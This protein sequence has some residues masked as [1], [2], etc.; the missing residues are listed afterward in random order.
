MKAQ[1]KLKEVSDASIK[2]GRESIATGL[3]A[4]AP[5]LAATKAFADQED[6]MLQM[7]AELLGD[8][9]TLNQK[10]FSDL[11]AYAN[12]AA[13]KYG[14]SAAEYMK[15]IR[16][17]RENSIEPKDILGGI[18]DAV[19]KLSVLF[20]VPPDSIAQFAARMKQDMGILPKEMIGM[21]DLIA[22][23]KNAG[24]GKDGAEAVQEMGE[25]FSK[26][27][28]GAHNLGV[29]GL[30]SAKDLGALMGIFISQGIWNDFR[31]L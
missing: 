22:R 10:V 1:K 3:A 24:V 20:H 12:G 26:A 11:T 29:S 31:L 5:L 16:V 28:L 7:K 15:M 18:G 21:T 17:L 6:A 4:A 9:N 23:L 13:L 14:E 30:Q 2:Y 8:G 25:A 27:G 19:E